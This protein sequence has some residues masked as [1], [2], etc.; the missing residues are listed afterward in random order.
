MAEDAN[1]KEDLEAIDKRIEEL[2]EEIALAEALERL[3]ENEDFKKVILDAYFEKEAKR[4]FELLTEPTSLKREQ[5]E[6]ITDMLATIRYFKGYFKTILINAHMAPDQ[7]QENDDYRV[8]L[9]NRSK[10]DQEE[11]KE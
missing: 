10:E 6:N 11:S 1:L 4:L 5:L 3:H 7:I 2:K 9:L 8:E